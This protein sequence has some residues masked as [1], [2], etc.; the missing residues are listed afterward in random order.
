M[1]SFHVGI[2]KKEIWIY[3][4]KNWKFKVYEIKLSNEN[5]LWKNIK[6][7]ATQ[8]YA[9]QCSQGRRPRITFTELVKQIP[10]KYINIIF[11]DHIDNL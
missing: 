1:V 4:I 6:V 7:N 3:I 11:Y 10:A 8:T 2:Q 9:D 5:N